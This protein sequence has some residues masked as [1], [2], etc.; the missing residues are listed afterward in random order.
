MISNTSK[1]AIRAMIYLELYAT[2]NKK[3]G[4]KQIAGELDIPSPFLGKILQV[5]V[6]HKLLASNKGPNGGFYL[7]RPAIDIS[8]MEIIQVMEGDNLFNNCAIRTAPCDPDHP[9]SIHN[10]LAPAREEVKRNFTNE[11]IADL[12]AEFREGKERIRI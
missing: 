6:R 9:C 5:L 8:L 4:I 2:P 1:Y 3:V 7:E 10:K 11:T 12:V